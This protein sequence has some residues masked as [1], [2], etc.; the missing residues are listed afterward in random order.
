MDGNV[1][2]PAHLTPEQ[3]EERRLAAA[4]LLRQGRLPQADI[5]RQL[6]V[7]RASICRWAATLAYVN[8]PPDHC[9]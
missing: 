9:G 4:R 1:C 2:R 6:G 3:L 7:S 8:A 5:A